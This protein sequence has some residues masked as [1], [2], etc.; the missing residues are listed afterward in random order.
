MGRSSLNGVIA[1]SGSSLSQYSNDENATTS[2][3]EIA[4]AHNCPHDSEIHLVNCM[5]NKSAEEIVKHDSKIQIERLSAK[6]MIK[7]M[8]G[9]L[10]FA[11]NIEQ[12]DDQRG[13]PGIITE[14]PQEVL[15]KEPKFKIPLLIGNVAH[16]T[17]NAF[18]IDEITK[19]FK[20]GTEFLKA[21]ANSLQLGSLLKAPNNIGSGFLGALGMQIKI[22]CQNFENKKFFSKV[23]HL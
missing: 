12:K 3:E 17:A 8:T 6:N 10:S 20:S 13:L 11:P 9:M 22:S 14:K 7:T 19:H 23:F 16:E 18:K 15:Q 1:M 4:N 21:T 5:R 2:T